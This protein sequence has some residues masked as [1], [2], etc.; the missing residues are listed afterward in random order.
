GTII[1]AMRLR[2]WS[3]IPFHVHCLGKTSPVVSL[4]LST[5]L[6]SRRSGGPDF[7]QV[8]FHDDKY[9]DAV[10]RMI[11]QSPLPL[12]GDLLLDQV[13]EA[14][15]NYL[16]TPIGKRQFITLYRDMILLSAWAGDRAKVKKITMECL[17]LPDW[18]KCQFFDDR[19]AFESECIESI[20]SQLLIHRV[21]DSQVSALGIA[22]LPVS[23]L[24][25]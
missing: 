13:I 8:A 17:A 7:V 11:E 23:K 24:I 10:L 15:K 6:R 18:T 14:Y 21:V 3:E 25:I 1:H 5:P 19:A 22:N 2:D 16:L 4:T 9:K 20:D 12:S